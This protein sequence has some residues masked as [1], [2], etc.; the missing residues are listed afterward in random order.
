[1]KSTSICFPFICTLL[2]A[3][4]VDQHP[5]VND[6][7][8]P[9]ADLR[10]RTY[11]GSAT[12]LVIP[13]ACASSKRQIAGQL[14]RTS[15]DPRAPDPYVDVKIPAGAPIGVGFITSANQ[16]GLG[17]CTD[18]AQFLPQPSEHYLATIAVSTKDPKHLMCV[19]R[20]YIPHKEED[21]TYWEQPIPVTTLN[22]SCH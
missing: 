9:T 3:A 17:T 21:G 6:I 7:Q 10:M 22:Q 14:T 19:L 18:F 16:P 15:K 5:Y 12:A 4:C 20:V 8:G 1:M 11:I 2:L 13:D